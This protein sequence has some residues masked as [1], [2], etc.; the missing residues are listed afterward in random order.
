MIAHPPPQ[1]GSIWI[2]K[3]TQQSMR[4]IYSSEHDIIAHNAELADQITLINSWRGSQAAFDASFTKGDPETY[5][6]TAH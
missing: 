1:P 6:E 5:P 4:V 2:N 3:H